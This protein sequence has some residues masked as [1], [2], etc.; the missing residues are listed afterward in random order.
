MEFAQHYYTVRE[1]EGSVAVCVQISLNSTSDI[2]ECDVVTIL[3]AADG[4]KAGTCTYA[5]HDNMIAIAR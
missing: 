4:N 2:L 5:S 1:G 3:S